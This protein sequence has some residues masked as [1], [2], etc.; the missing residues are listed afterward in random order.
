MFWGRKG[1]K[2]SA[3]ISRAQA[4]HIAMIAAPLIDMEKCL[5]C[6]G[7]A[8]LSSPVCVDHKADCPGDQRYRQISAILE[9]LGKPKETT[10]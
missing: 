8:A 4:D 10:E 5:E 6:G 3:K 2:K 9:S 7:P 1:K